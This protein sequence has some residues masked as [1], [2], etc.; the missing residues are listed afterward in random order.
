M[1]TPSTPPIRQP[2]STAA[3]LK[4]VDLIR[5]RDLELLRLRSQYQANEITTEALASAMEAEDEKITEEIFEIVSGIYASL[6]ATVD[7][8]MQI[9]EQMKQLRDLEAARIAGPAH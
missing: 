3:L 1:G 7:S 4:I 8:V 5:A 6:E 9:Q 2:F